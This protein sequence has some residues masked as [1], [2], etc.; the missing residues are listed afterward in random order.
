MIKIAKHTSICALL[1]FLL[2]FLVWLSK[3]QWQPNSNYYWC[4]I[5][6]AQPKINVISWSILIIFIFL[7]WFL[8]CLQ[9]H[10]KQSIILII[11]FIIAMIIGQAIKHVIKNYVQEIR[12]FVVWLD[13]Q[14]SI[15]LHT[16]YTMPNK[17]RINLLKNELKKNQAIPQWLKIYWCNE[18]GY[19]FPSGHTLFFSSWTI[20][21]VVVLWPR[22][23]FV[24]A[25]LT[26]IFT[27]FIIAS[28]M[29]LG[30]HWPEDIM[31][32]IFLSWLAVILFFLLVQYSKLLTLI[33]LEPIITKSNL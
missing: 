33:L 7:F 16:F 30:M 3:W 5:L 15:N 24:F 14:H 25:I 29:A 23:H 8:Y 17:E 22:R 21:I 32:S 12:P 2:P 18:T 13:Q 6:Y 26:M 31:I 19:S 9:C 1:L 10:I 4:K 20:L 27:I 11:I 28:R